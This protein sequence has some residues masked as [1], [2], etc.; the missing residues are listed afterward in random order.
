MCSPK[1]AFK[2]SGRVLGVWTALFSVALA[3][4]QLSA[5]MGD[6]TSP[7]Q[8]LNFP[9]ALH[10]V[11]VYGSSVPPP[12]NLNPEN[13][14]I[15]GI[16]GSSPNP[17]GEMSF[18]ITEGIAL[19]ITQ[20]NE[21][22]IHVPKAYRLDCLAKALW[23]VASRIPSSGEYWVV[24]QEVTRAVRDIEQL[25]H[26]NKD[27]SKP[28]ILVRDANTNVATPRLTPVR[29]ENINSSLQMA[30]DILDEAA[31]VLLRSAES[32]NG[33]AL[34]YQTIA[35]AINSNKVLLRST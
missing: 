9:S 25:I 32:S 35:E 19:R 10:K 18:E 2:Y 33:V 7:L 3:P 24:K 28:Q 4:S 21:I 12:K 8:N 20:I 1:C 22:C 15:G 26:R 34:H 13:Q 23:V 6:F 5:K 14:D 11:Q 16:P 27:L 31:T 29:P 17:R 30:E